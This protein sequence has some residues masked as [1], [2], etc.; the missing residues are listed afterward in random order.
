MQALKILHEFSVMLPK[1]QFA[2]IAAF[3]KEHPKWA[4][5][6]LPSPTAEFGH[7]YLVRILNENGIALQVAR[8]KDQN[9]AFRE[10]LHKAE[11]MPG[12]A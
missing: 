9:E 10:A 11:E 7:A 1:L 12:D 4:F 5:E 3:R 6:L 2:L 8:N